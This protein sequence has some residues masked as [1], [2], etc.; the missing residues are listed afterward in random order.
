S[1]QERNRYINL[2]QLATYEKFSIN[3]LVSLFR[4]MSEFGEILVVLA[5]PDLVRWRFFQPS[6][7]RAGH[8]LG[9]RPHYARTSHTCEMCRERLVRMF[10]FCN[11]AEFCF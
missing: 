7:G 6:R 10:K 5:A 3:I 1:T 11:A 8:Y 9:A 2:Y 4:N